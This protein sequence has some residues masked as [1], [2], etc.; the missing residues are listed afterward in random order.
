V[1]DQQHKILTV[2]YGTFSG[3]GTAHS[4]VSTNDYAALAATPDGRLAIAYI[5][6]ARTVT[7]DMSKFSAPVTARWFDPTNA[8]ITSANATVLQNT[9]THTFTSPGLNSEGGS[10]SDWVLLL[11]VKPV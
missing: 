4:S 9:G 6:S 5:P 11:E 7:I 10:S 8:E 3:G 1:P 2:G